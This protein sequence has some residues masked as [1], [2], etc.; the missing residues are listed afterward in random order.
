MCP[1]AKAM[2]NTVSPKASATP[3][4]PIPKPGKAASRTAAPQPP[5]TSQNV[6][7]NSA[8]DLLESDIA[9]FLQ[10][11]SCTRNCSRLTYHKTASRSAPLRPK[12]YWA[13]K[14]PFMSQG[15]AALGGCSPG[16]V[17]LA[18]GIE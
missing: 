7:M 5:N 11:G 12:L 10:W 9:K 6:P 14:M 1:M 13:Y 17:L 4:N 18:F 16:N 8:N 15:Y 3:T 2:V